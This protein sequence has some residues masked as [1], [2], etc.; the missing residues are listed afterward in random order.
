MQNKKFINVLTFYVTYLWFTSF[1]GAILPTHFLAQGINYNQMILGKFL[2]FT[3]P[4]VLLVFLKSFSSKIAWRLAPF[5]YLMFVLLSIKILGVTQFYIASIFIGFSIFFFYV[6]YNIA[7]FRNTQKEKTGHS[8]AIMF[9]LGPI[10]NILAPLASGYIANIS[11]TLLWILAI[12]SFFVCIFFAEKQESFRVSYTVKNALREIRAT[13][14]F[15]FIGGIWEAIPFGII[16]V[17][18]LYFIKDPLPYGAY[19]AYL[20]LIAV[21]ANLVLG[22]ITDRIQKRS[23]FLYPITIAMALI[24]FLLYFSIDNL[25]LWIVATSLLQ[26]VLPLFWNISTAMVI[27]THSNLELAIPG[28]E[29]MLTSGRIIG[30]LLT[31]LSLLIEKTPKDIFIFLGFVILLYPTLLFWNTRITKKY[32][33]L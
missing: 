32:S 28:R 27:D 2:I 17:F 12:V 21:F 31:F 20:S 25:Y 13:R 10:I 24:T 5:S 8:S 33:Y 29:I 9:S 14:L 11:F 26:F 1:G 3:S 23:I 18:T 7:H 16:P 6:F 30:L 22:K 15:I 19:L 4:L